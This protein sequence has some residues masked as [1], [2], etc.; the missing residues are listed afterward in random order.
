MCQEETRK[1]FE[2]GFELLVLCYLQVENLQPSIQGNARYRNTLEGLATITRNQGWRQL[3]AGLSINYIK[4]ILE[5]H[6][7][8]HYAFTQLQCKSQFL[9]LFTEGEFR[10]CFFNFALFCP[11]T[12][13]HFVYFPAFLLDIS[14][15]T[16]N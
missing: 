15:L 12:L 11:E 2:S 4:V 14:I 6:C 8:N 16:F 5:L 7:S 1:G 10:Y 13:N 3:F 9:P